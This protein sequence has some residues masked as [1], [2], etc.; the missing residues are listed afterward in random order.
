MLPQE[1]FTEITLLLHITG[2]R[3]FNFPENM[4]VELLINGKIVFGLVSLNFLFFNMMWQE[5]SERM[6]Y[7]ILHVPYPLRK[8][9]EKVLWSLVVCVGVGCLELAKQYCAKIQGNVFSMCTYWVTTLFSQ[10][11]FSFLTASDIFQDTNLMIN[12]A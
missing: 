11:I 9:L 7:L 2:K 3:D 12:R 1:T 10:F 8:S 4:R 6:K 5:G